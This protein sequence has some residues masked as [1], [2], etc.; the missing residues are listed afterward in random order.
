VIERRPDSRELIVERCNQ[1]AAGF[2]RKQKLYS[3]IWRKLGSQKEVYQVCKMV[4]FG[5]ALLALLKTNCQTDDRNVYY[6]RWRVVG[7]EEEGD[8]PEA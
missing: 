7:R 5:T 3:D 6:F 1:Y 4:M 8:S 2:E